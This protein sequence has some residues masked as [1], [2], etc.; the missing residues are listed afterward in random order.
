MFSNDATPVPSTAEFQVS[1]DVTD[2]PTEAG[3]AMLTSDG[4]CVEGIVYAGSVRTWIASVTASATPCDATLALAG[5]GG[6]S[7]GGSS[8]STPAEIVAVVST[9]L[10]GTNFTV[11]RIACPSAGDCT[12]LGTYVDSSGTTEYFADTETG[13]TWAT[14]AQILASLVAADGAAVN[15]PML[16]CPAPGDCVALGTDSSQGGGYGATYVATSSGGA[17]TSPTLLSGFDAYDYPTTGPSAFACVS[18]GN[19]VVPGYLATSAGSGAVLEE[20][21][22]IWG[23]P[24]VVATSAP[25]A[26]YSPTTMA[27]DF[28]APVTPEAAACGDANLADCVVVGSELFANSTKDAVVDGA[29]I[30]DQAGT[31]AVSATPFSESVPNYSGSYDANSFDAYLSSVACSGSTCSAAGFEEVGDNAGGSGSGPSSIPAEVASNA[32][33][34]WTAENVPGASYGGDV[35]D[36]YGRATATACSGAGDC[37]VAAE[38]LTGA[39]TSPVTTPLVDT[40]V[41]GVWESA[42]GPSAASGDTTSDPSS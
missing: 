18:V 34:S 23:S 5:P 4:G 33:G 2:N 32:S 21:G 8:G 11:T 7:G 1:V 40:Q 41:S 22:G 27:A 42:Q 25:P 37:V 20:T 15:P 12:V 6:S 10:A 35:L 30:T 9:G 17:W 29:V 24:Q 36:N 38:F 31:W 28:A 26:G 39:Y 13:G 19:C 14:P 16:S 3:M